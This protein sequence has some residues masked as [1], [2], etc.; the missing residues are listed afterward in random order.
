MVAT[1]K[2]VGACGRS[3]RAERRPRDVSR[4]VTVGHNVGVVMISVVSRVS[5]CSAREFECQSSRWCGQRSNSIVEHLLVLLLL[6]WRA[7]FDPPLE[8]TG[9][10]SCRACSRRPQIRGARTAHGRWRRAC[11]RVWWRA[12]RAGRAAP[13]SHRSTRSR[14]RARCVPQTSARDSQRSSLRL[15]WLRTA[16]RQSAATAC[17]T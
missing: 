8:R 9:R 11:S 16:R 3:A 10:G 14:P 12:R 7:V 6:Y 15:G 17:G 13:R 2:D 1:L 5:G 4:A